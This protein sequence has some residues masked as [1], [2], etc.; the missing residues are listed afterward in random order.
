MAAMMII[1][2]MV[3]ILFSKQL[4]TFFTTKNPMTI[5]NNSAI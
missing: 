4:A 2:M 3:K 1:N 5:I